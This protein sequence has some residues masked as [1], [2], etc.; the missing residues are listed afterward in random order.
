MFNK[1]RNATQRLALCG[2]LAA[3]GVALMS[4]G[5]LIPLTTY[6]CPF[7]CMVTMKIVLWYCGKKSA[8]V[9]FAA[10]CVLSWLLCADR[11][12]VIVFTLFGWYPLIKPRLDRTKLPWLWKT[13]LFNVTLVAMY[14]VLLW[15]VG[16]DESET[17]ILLLLLAVLWN[18]TLHFF[19]R[20]LTGV[21]RL[22]HKLGEPA[23]G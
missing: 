12:A 21:E 7:L 20:A 22:L 14:Y 1:N 4:L 15:L 19:D 10:V 8:R 11:E 2:V 18:I 9:W 13:L 6:I 16:V 17:G 23:D 3:L 5:T